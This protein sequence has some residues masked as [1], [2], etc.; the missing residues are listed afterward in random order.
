MA[1]ASKIIGVDIN[2]DKFEIA[3]QLGA[4]DCV[5][6]KEV[7]GPIQQH[8]AGKMTKWGVDYTFDCTGTTRSRRNHF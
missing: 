2:P 8:I 3:K 7:E 1:G 4:T 5:N 6:S